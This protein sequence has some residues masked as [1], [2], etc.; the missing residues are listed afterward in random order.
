MKIAVVS[1][2]PV[3]F[4]TGG[5]EKLTWH[6]VNSINSQTS[7]QAELIKIPL[8]EQTFLQVIRS[9]LRFRLL[10]LNHFDLVISTK[11]PSWMIR[12]PYHIVYMVHPLRGVYDTYDG[13]R[14]LRY[15]LMESPLKMAGIY[16]RFFVHFCD[17]IAL[18]PKRMLSYFAI[19]RTVVNRPDYFPKGS[20]VEILY[21]PSPLQT[22]EEGGKREIA[23]EFE[24]YRPYFFT[25]SRL[26]GPKRIEMI[27]EAI[28]LLDFPCHLLIAGEGPRYQHLRTVA[29]N[30]SRIIFLGKVSD[31]QLKALYANSLA[32]IFIPIQEDYGL[33]TIESL[34]MKRP[35]ITTID[36]GGPS[37]IIDDGKEGFIVSPIPYSIAEKMKFLLENRE[38]ADRLGKAGFEKVRNITWKNLVHD[39]LKNHDYINPRF[40]I[41]TGKQKMLVLSTYPIFPS[42]GGGQERIYNVYRLLSEHFDITILSLRPSDKPFA[43]NDITDTCLE[44]SIPQSRN[45]SIAQWQIQEE[46]KHTVT[47]ILMA[48]LVH[49]TP[50]FI[51][52]LEYY[53]N[54][55]DIIVAS[56]PFL[57]PLI[58]RKRKEQLIIYESHNVEYLLKKSFLPP[59]RKGKWLLSKVKKVEKAACSKSDIVFNTSP[60]EQEK[61]ASLYNLDLKKAYIS[62]NGVDTELLVPK[63]EDEK[64]MA[65]KILGFP[66]QVII[67]FMGSWHP[68]NLDAFSFIL[69]ELSPKLPEAHFVVM[70]SVREEF[71]AMYG[72]KKFPQNVSA[73][74]AVNEKTKRL[75]LQSADIAINP[76]NHGSGTNLK[77]LDYMASGIPIVSTAIGA[78]GFNQDELSCFLINPRSEFYQSLEKLLKNA[79]LKETLSRKARELV[80]ARF[81]WKV[82]MAGMHEV[83]SRLTPSNLQSS[84]TVS[85]DKQLVSGWYPPETWIVSSIL[86]NQKV[87]VRW[88]TSRAEFI[89]PN[90]GPKMKL[91]IQF[92]AF[93]MNLQ[94]QIMLDNDQQIIFDDIV[95]CK[96]NRFNCTFTTESQDRELKFILTTQTWIPS[97]FYNNEDNR[98]LGVPIS[99]FGIEES[100]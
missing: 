19:S 61:L 36:S 95:P 21:P 6:L 42:Q 48:H 82:I 9:Y 92:E 7:H 30:D 34:Q 24:E 4:T 52:I 45:H 63:S 44:I 1:P 64:L 60:E 22:I 37:E 46:M 66:D 86:G 90:L 97:Q 58:K 69:N 40:E 55:S 80:K 32:T 89:L 72:R 39:L 73:V 93:A 94:A 43:R 26:D 62:S 83:I 51:S 14:K 8:H 79:E 85:D 33:V 88:T 65:K 17:S 68:P 11:Y 15:L 12:H 53:L 16:M 10:R 50:K 54:K 18:S 75:I 41:D 20:R 57:F 78:R 84:F 29:G 74:G 91:W 76:V 96:R 47:D 67:L 38:L 13:P 71:Y 81:D 70:G 49:L 100:L 35:V 2:S 98:E 87:L 56:H 5:L 23:G 25:I 27:I 3:P 77:M 99:S 28:K 59:S 31:A